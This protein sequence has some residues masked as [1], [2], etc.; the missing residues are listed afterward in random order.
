VIS[1]AARIAALREA[2]YQGPV[3]ALGFADSGDRT[4]DMTRNYWAGREARHRESQQTDAGRE[5]G[6]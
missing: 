6:S 4:A 2:G 3:D 1:P 5:A